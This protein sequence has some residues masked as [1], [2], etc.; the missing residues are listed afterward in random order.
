MGIDVRK[1]VL[2]KNASVEQTKN[3]ESSYKM[4]MNDNDM[5][6]SFKFLAAIHGNKVPP[7]F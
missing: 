3:I 5:G 1:Q 6:N 7:G 2:L 4:L